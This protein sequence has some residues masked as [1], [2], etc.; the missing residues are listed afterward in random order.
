MIHYGNKEGETSSFI[1]ILNAKL[2]LKDEEQ[3]TD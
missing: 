2:I 3:L 1:S